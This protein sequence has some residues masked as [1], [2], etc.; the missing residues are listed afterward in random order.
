MFC[1]VMNA[2]TE[3][4][5]CLVLDNTSKSNKIEDCVYYYKAPIR[6]GFRIGSE[7]MWQYHQNNYNPRHVSAPLITSGTPAGSARRPGVTIKKV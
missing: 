5:E 7:A 4:Y 3:N 1:Q 2:C 6:K